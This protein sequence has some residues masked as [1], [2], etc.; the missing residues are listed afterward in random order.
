MTERAVPYTPI[1]R[2][3]PRIQK[4]MPIKQIPNLQWLNAIRTPLVPDSDTHR[5]QTVLVV[6]SDGA[7]ATVF[8]DEILGTAHLFS[9]IALRSILVKFRAM[10]PLNILVGALLLLFGRRLFWLFVAAMGFI[11][12]TTIATEW[13]GRGSAEMYLAIALV[14][15]IVGAVIS[16]FLQR[17]AVGTAGFFA[18]GYVLQ[19]LAAG[20]GYAAS[21][22]LTFQI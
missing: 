8:A 3:I 1:K 6:V 7:L 21:D 14:L 18:G 9:P 4:I 10:A 19:T 5:P 2:T 13:F 11:V 20:W 15:G 16:L 12:G 22:W 17:L